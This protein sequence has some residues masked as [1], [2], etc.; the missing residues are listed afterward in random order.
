MEGPM[1]HFTTRNRWLRSLRKAALILSAF[2]L[3]VGCTPSQPSAP[4]QQEQGT[5][6]AT[7]SIQ[8]VDILE[9]TP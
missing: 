3:A 5:A 9:A 2:N 6:S 4:T 1:T 8:A 7:F